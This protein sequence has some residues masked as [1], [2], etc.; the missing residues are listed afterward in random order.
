MAAFAILAIAATLRALHDLETMDVEV[1]RMD[2]R[3]GSLDE[4]DKK[5]GRLDEMAGNLRSMRAQLREA[6]ALLVR[7]DEK[8]DG[9]TGSIRSM[10]TTMRQADRHL[11]AVDGMR[12]DIHEM[13][14]KLAGSFL[15]RG[16][17]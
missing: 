4:M 15:F 13:S 10:V 6:N 14:H 12:A 7:A 5:L 8:L 1:Q 16:V 9:A 3:L 2:G 17:K 11:A